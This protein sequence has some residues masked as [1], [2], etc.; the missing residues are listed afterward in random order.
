[1]WK[2]DDPKFEVESV[3]FNNSPNIVTF[4]LTTGDER[5]YV[6]G[7]YIP[8]DCNKG[9][10][11]LRRAWDM[12]PPGCK[13]IVFGDLNINFGCSPGTNGKRTSRTYSTKSI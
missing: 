1:M 8:S 5:F 11:N 4:Q 3:L 7:I 2:E 13:P 10:D 9:V 6:I 12:C